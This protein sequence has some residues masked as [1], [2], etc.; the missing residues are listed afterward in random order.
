MG[1]QMATTGTDYGSLFR[2]RAR[3]QAQR[4]ADAEA[5]RRSG[6]YS[7]NTARTNNAPSQGDQRGGENRGVSAPKQFKARQKNM[8]YKEHIDQLRQLRALATESNGVLTFPSTELKNKWTNA[9][10]L[11]VDY[12][13]NNMQCDAGNGQSC[14]LAGRGQNPT[15]YPS[16]FADSE[17][18]NANSYFGVGDGSLE[19]RQAKRAQ[20]DGPNTGEGEVA[21]AVAGD[22]T[23]ESTQDRV[24]RER[25]EKEDAR[26]AKENAE[27]EPPRP[28]NGDGSGDGSGDSPNEP[29]ANDSSRTG[30]GASVL[31]P[32]HDEN[33]DPRSGGGS[34]SGADGSATHGDDG[35]GVHPFDSGGGSGSGRPKRPKRPAVVDIFGADNNNENKEYIRNLIALRNPYA[36]PCPA[37]K[38][39][40]VG[41]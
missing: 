39:K 30:G 29:N 17:H 3:T 9:R 19:D 20:R 41:R 18:F 35:T 23:V 34:H 14:M 16:P 25:N 24:A 13:Q 22:G 27:G 36:R 7:S 5:Q 15:D 26:V 32:K 28:S 40:M 8:E 37:S 10:A 33:H 21:V 4:N 38:L 11:A 31:K 6:D 12:E 1:T 2:P